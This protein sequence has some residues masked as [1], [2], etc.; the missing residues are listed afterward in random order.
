M[1]QQ[2]KVFDMAKTEN[3]IKK[4]IETNLR[5]D[6]RAFDQFRQTQIETDF[7][8]T[9]EGSA[10]VLIG[11][12]QVIAGVK[13]DVIEPYPDTPNEGSLVVDCELVP[14]ASP[15]FEPG[16]PNEE[17]VEIARVVD[18]GIRES[19][20]IDF[21][22]LCIT[23]GE[24]AWTV[25]IDVHIIDHDGNL[26]DAA[27]LAAISALL[28][29]RIPKLDTNNKP[30]RVMSKEGQALLPMRD[31]PVEITIGKINST[32]LVDGNLD[33]ETAFDARLTLA[34]NSAG[35][36]CA[37]QKGGKGWFTTDELL[38]AAD[39]AIEKAEELRKLLPKGV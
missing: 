21:E 33:E 8:G 17:A 38:K 19:H 26:I 31:K 13:M 20:C 36:L 29:A 24:L 16:P 1:L 28:T 9:A 4:L 23:P 15:E 5:I 12:T 6:G 32:F 3:Y 25:H 34:V 7:I 2:W 35:N 22:K 39:I 37:A 30:V 11:N 18:R 10:R 14:L 27:A